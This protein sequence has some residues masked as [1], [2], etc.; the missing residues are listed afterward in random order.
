VVAKLLPVILN[1]EQRVMTEDIKVLWKPFVDA[2]AETV[3]GVRE[4]IE[5]ARANQKCGPVRISIGPD[6]RTAID[7]VLQF[8]AVRLDATVTVQRI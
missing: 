7:P 5:A 3:F 4:K 6:K 8:P 2:L 1:T